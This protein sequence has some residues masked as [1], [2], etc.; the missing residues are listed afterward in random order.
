MPGYP[1]IESSLTLPWA[2]AAIGWGFVFV[3]RAEM[4]R[5]RA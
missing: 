4:L 3:A 5:L 1:D 2:I